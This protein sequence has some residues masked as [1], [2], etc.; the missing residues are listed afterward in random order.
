[1]D[2]A[3][4]GKHPPAQLAAMAARTNSS[5]EHSQEEASYVDSGTNSH[6][7]AA[8]ENLS[9]QEPY[10]GDKEIV[11]G[12]GTGLTIANQGS[13]VLFNSSTPFKLNNILHCLSATP[14]LLST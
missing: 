3:Y 5:M 6:V 1:M 12:N 9:I 4:Q 2:N 11:V 8:L 14:N 10:K 7:I 13:T